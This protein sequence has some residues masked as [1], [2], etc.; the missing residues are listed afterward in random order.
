MAVETGITRAFEITGS[1]VKFQPLSLRAAAEA[2]EPGRIISTQ[3]YGLGL[4]SL[5]YRRAPSGKTTFLERFSA[6]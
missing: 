3:C 1:A 2:A 6:A 4:P 5:S